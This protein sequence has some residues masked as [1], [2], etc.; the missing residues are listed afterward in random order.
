MVSSLLQLKCTF[1]TSEQ[2]DAPQVKINVSCPLLLNISW[3][4]LAT[5][6]LKGPEFSS[7]SETQMD[8]FLDQGLPGT[9]A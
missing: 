7:S 2:E 9:V 8:V 4:D 1:C 5:F 6:H 3:T